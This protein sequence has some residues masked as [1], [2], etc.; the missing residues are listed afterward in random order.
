MFSI[1]IYLRFA[2]I[3]L[4]IVGGIAL[5]AAYG[6]GY[7]L[8]FVIVGVILLIG[9]LLVGTIMSTNMLLGQMRL[10]EAEQRL[11]MTY[12]PNLLMP[13]YKGVFFMTKGAIAMQKKDWANAESMIKTAL[14]SGLPT[15]NERGAA[16]LQ[17]L[18]IGA[19]RNPN[20]NVITQK[21]AEIK[22]LNITD[23]SL[24]EQIKEVEGQ[25]KL[26]AQNPMNPSTMA[27]M[28]GRGGFRQ[29]GGKRP[30]PKM[31]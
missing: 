26:A 24:K 21:L 18:M 29:G 31:R 4:G 16:M 6:W 23:S 14:D 15:D 20:R 11:N 17:L 2:L 9:Y 5:W 3:A 1:N 13:G 8:P 25:L 22:K 10:D 19:Q 12:F 7:G 28:G 30:R 27:M